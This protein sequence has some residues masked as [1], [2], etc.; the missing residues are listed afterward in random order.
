MLKLFLIAILILLT[1]GQTTDGEEEAEELNPDSEAEPELV[2]NNCI[3]EDGEEI[4][5]CEIIVVE[6]EIVE[7]E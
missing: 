2:V 3:D 4:E 5:D 7:E 6:P 1:Y